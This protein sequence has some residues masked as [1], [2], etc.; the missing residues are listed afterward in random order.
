MAKRYRTAEQET[1]PNMVASMIK[2]ALR[3]GIEGDYLLADAWFGS[4]AILRLCEETNLVAVLRM[5]KS[6]LKYRVTDTVDG[7]QVK[8]NLDAKALYQHS[9]RKQWQRIAGQKYQAK[10]VDV[11]VNLTENKKDPAKWTKVRL[12]VVRGTTEQE[13]AQVGKHDWALFL[14][15]DLSMSATDILQL[16]ALRWAIEVYFKEAK[17]HLGLLKEQS[18]HYAAY[19]ASIHLSAIRFCLLVMAKQTQEAGSVVQI[20]HELC[21]NSQNISFSQ[22]LWPVLTNISSFELNNGQIN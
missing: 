22:Q 3:A 20:R 17:Q 7:R 11:E 2:R 4:K 14:C 8:Q 12:L 16:Y 6:K 18:N 21:G 10:V 19:I 15:T 5:K 9:A 1:K 13:K